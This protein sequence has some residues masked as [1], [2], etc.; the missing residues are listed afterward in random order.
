M[1]VVVVVVVA[2]LVIVA[3]SLFWKVITARTTIQ[4][5]GF[6]LTSEV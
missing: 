5:D 6:A 2:V 3:N 4:K 1:V